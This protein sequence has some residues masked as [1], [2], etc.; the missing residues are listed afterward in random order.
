MGV[1]QELVKL[2]DFLKVPANRVPF[3]SNA[4]QAMDGAGIVWSGFPP[5]F[6]DTL[7]MRSRNVS[8]SMNSV[9]IKCVSALVL[10]PS[11]TVSPRRGCP[12]GD[13]GVGL[14]PISWMVTMLG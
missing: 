3:H 9:A 4:R 5:S 13:P 2:S 14:L 7:R 8:P 6:I 12:A 10:E 1:E 11:L